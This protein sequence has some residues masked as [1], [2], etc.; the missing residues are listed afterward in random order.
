ME[1]HILCITEK[2]WLNSTIKTGIIDL[3]VDIE[4]NIDYP[5][6]ED[7][8]DVRREKFKDS[9]QTTGS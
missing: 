8:E 3:L 1:N 4:A 9:T 7:I 5:E 2:L 6:Y